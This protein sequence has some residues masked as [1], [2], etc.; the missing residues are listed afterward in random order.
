MIE[1]RKVTKTYSGKDAV[2]VTA[3]RDVSLVVNLS[4]YDCLQ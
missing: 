1:L 4:F 2:G 3:V